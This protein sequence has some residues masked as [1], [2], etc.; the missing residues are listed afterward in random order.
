M[1]DAVHSQRYGVLL[2]TFGFGFQ[3]L[4]REIVIVLLVS[5]IGPNGGCKVVVSEI[6]ADGF[7]RIVKGSGDLAVGENDNA[8]TE[9]LDRAHAMT[10]KKNRAA[11]PSGIAH[12]VE[13]LRLKAHVSYG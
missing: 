9:A 12:L 7:A 3:S 6:K 10:N 13:A 5:A 4:R 8:I 2:V 11:G 1:H